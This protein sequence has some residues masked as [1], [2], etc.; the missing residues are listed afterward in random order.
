MDTHFKE[1]FHEFSEDMPSGCFHRVI[2]LHEEPLITWS[3]ISAL[4]PDLTKA[5]Y[6]LSRLSPEDRI[7]FTKEYWIQKLIY[8]P[9]LNEFLDSF[10]D[11]LDEIGVFLIQKKFDDP[12]DIFL[13]YSLTNDS[14]FYRGML[15]VKED[16]VLTM[17][18][19][20][21][22]I[23]FPPDYLAFLRIHN[24]F[25]KTT[26][27]TGVTRAGEMKEQYEA[28]QLLFADE[29]GLVT[30]SGQ[31]LDPKKLIPFYVSF[32][33][34]YY[35]CFWAEWYPQ[36][37]MGVVYVRGAE[38]TVSDIPR[39]GSYMEGRAFP[40]FTDWLMFYLERIG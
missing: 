3:D 24:G 39:D 27:S 15:P 2:A 37:E 18:T 9:K 22:D 31:P 6:E 19:L 5:W 28:F 30:E 25:F 4:A 40:T 20:F 12:F 7:E 32:G 11:G 34:P 35:H 17:E 26:D 23:I 36:H 16:E 38:K 21:P 8:H 33:M 13:V 29:H 10:F 1:F 14:G